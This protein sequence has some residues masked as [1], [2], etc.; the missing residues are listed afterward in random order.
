MGC[1]EVDR[2]A[3]FFTSSSHQRLRGRSGGGLLGSIP[4]DIEAVVGVWCIL[5]PLEQGAFKLDGHLGDR[6]CWQLNEHLQ[7]VGL[8]PVLGRLVV[9][10][11]WMEARATLTLLLNSDYIS[12]PIFLG[13][14]M[15][16]KLGKQVGSQKRENMFPVS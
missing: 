3:V 5:C 16:V 14:K 4:P 15:A 1:R 9:D 2:R 13:A 7:E 12:P 6:V 10:I 11:T 8:L